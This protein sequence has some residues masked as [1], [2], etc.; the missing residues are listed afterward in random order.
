M[1]LMLTAVLALSAGK[2]SAQFEGTF[3][4]G[5]HLKYGAEIA[6][7]GA[8]VHLHYY[9]TNAIR[10]APSF[11]YY[12]PRKGKSL[13]EVEADAHYIVPLSWDISLYPIAGLNYGNWKYDA[14][15]GGD[16]TW[17]DGRKKRMGANAGLGLQYDLGYRV[18][19]NFEFK[20]QF[21]RDFSQLTV[22]AGI[23]F[24]L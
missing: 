22:M 16:L 1:L 21:I 10:W 3:G 19:A 2:A 17:Q 5:T 23:G 14:G 18:R 24:W 8:G 9:K 7:T 12:L 11:T 15:Q 13:W 4:M 6:S 20:Y